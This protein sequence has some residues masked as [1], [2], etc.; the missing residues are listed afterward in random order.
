MEVVKEQL[1]LGQ[2]H[3]RR[4]GREYVLPGTIFR[5]PW[6]GAKS[7]FDFLSKQK[8]VPSPKK[9]PTSSRHCH[10]PHDPGGC[11]SQHARRQ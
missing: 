2:L 3:L 1:L 9:H 7:Y 8:P 6:N 10:A 4:G 5:A 11:D